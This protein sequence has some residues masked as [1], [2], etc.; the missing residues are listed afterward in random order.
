MALDSE[1]MNQSVVASTFLSR[2]KRSNGPGW[3]F[4]TL[5]EPNC[6]GPWRKNL[7]G[8]L[9]CRGHLFAVDISVLWMHSVLLVSFLQ[10]QARHLCPVW[11]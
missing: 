10:N 2:Q 8:I 1:E 4:E 9:R 3:T 6:H 5:K 7:E 11:I